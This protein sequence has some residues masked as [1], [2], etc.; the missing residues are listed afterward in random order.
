MNGQLKGNLPFGSF[1][2]IERC[3]Q[4]HVVSNLQPH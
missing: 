1:H 4:V 2:A 3:G